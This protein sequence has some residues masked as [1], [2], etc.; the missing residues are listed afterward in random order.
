MKKQA[1]LLSLLM[2][3][4]LASANAANL[5]GGLQT[6]AYSSTIFAL[7]GAAKCTATKIAE[8]TYITAAHCVTTRAVSDKRPESIKRLLNG[9]DLILLSKENVVKGYSDFTVSYVGEVFVNPDY[10]YYTYLHVKGDIS[11]FKATSLAY[12]VAI[13]TVVSP[14]GVEETASISAEPIKSGS[15]I[16]VVGYGCEDNF[17]DRS[18]PSGLVGRKKAG[19]MITGTVLNDESLAF[20]DDQIKFDLDENYIY[21]QVMNVEDKVSICPGD[22]GG[23]VFSGGKLVGISSFAYADDNGDAFN[24]MFSRVSNIFEWIESITKR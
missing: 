12:D 16:D 22:S 17:K 14:L 6:S 24:N 9:G 2:I 7:L 21:A 5:I 23:P 18:V 10:D 19:S 15:K 3:P 1:I 20:L 13:F 11:D 4:T 8:K